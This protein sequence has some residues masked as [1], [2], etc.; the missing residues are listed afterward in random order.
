MSDTQNPNPAQG[1]PA[2]NAAVIGA[3]MVAALLV[4]G[5]ANAL[6]LTYAGSIPGT[7]DV[8]VLNYALALEEFEAAL[9]Q[10]ALARLTALGVAAGNKAFDLLTEFSVVEQDHATFL[11]GALAQTSGPVISQF[12]YDFSTVTNAASAQSVLELVLQV[13]A[14]GV[15]AYLGAIPLLS[16]GSKYLQIAAAIQGTEARHT[17]V[18]TIARNQLYAT[19]TDI[20]PI[21]LD[22][23]KSGMFPIS[24]FKYET[25]APSGYN[26]LKP[27]EGVIGIDANLS[28]DTVLAAVGPFFAAPVSG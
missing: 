12:T 10:A 16:T 20:A 9:Y 25:Y 24:A 18:L 27:N 1:H 19:T 6:S 7:G 23:N 8:K 14:T 2:R 13:E 5:R 11:R 22:N 15:R 28:P 21:N 3:G 26:P 17:S 4:S